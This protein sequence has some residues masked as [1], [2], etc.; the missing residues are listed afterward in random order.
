MGNIYRLEHPEPQFRRENWQN[1]NGIWQFEIDHGK[2]GRARGM[3]KSD[4]TFN[5]CINV[6]FCPESELSDIGNKDYMSAVWYRREIELTEEQIQD[7]TIL[8]HIGACDYDTQIWVNEKFAGEHKGGFSP[9]CVD[10]TDYVVKG[11][12]VVTVVAE[13]DVRKPIPRGKQ[14]DRYESYGCFYTRTTGIWQTVW[15]EFV[16]K[17]YIQTVRFCTDIKSESVIISAKLAGK[18]DFR[19]DIFFEGKKVGSVKCD[20]C[21]D[22]CNLSVKLDEIHLWDLGQGNLYDVELHFGEDTVFSYFGLR[23]VAVEGNR[24]LLNGRSVFQRLVLDQGFY[25]DGI[26]TAP[27]DEALKKDIEL[28]MAAGFN[29]ARL[30]QKVFE[31]RFLYHCDKLGYMVWGEYPDWGLEFS[32]VECIR[33]ILPE[34]TEILK[35]DINHPSIIGWCPFNETWWYGKQRS[36]QEDDVLRVLYQQ[37]KTID[38]SRLCIDSSGSLHVASDM[39]DVHD[40]EQRVDVFKEKY[41]HISETGV[42]PNMYNDYNKYDGKQPVFISE[43]GGIGLCTTSGAWSY[44]EHTKNIGE[45]IERYKGLTHSIIDNPAICA[46]CYTQLYDVEQEQN[47]LYTYDRKPKIDISII[48]EIN[49]KKA[50]IEEGD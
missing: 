46:M 39:Y 36:H 40:Y 45:Y 48:K 28:S 38:P 14:S 16:P 17:A 30:H 27:S 24:F 50:A 42:V 44:G 4:Y 43:Y 41:S 15:L 11:K 19:A 33:Y 21:Q 7:K 25:P 8:F 2:S 31:P 35:R 18:A 5:D 26:Y 34:W 12:N 49:S 1:L 47:G 13:D 6:P 10:I 32:S 20:N 9:I 3:I 22:F 37:T 23:D 29:G